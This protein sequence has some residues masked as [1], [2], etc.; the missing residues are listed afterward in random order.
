[1]KLIIS[2]L[3]LLLIPSNAW[4][5]V[6][7]DYPGIYIHQMGHIYFILSSAFILWTIVHN[8]LQN[9]KSWRYLFIGN[10]F[11][12]LW[13]LDAFI[14]HITEFWIEPS[15]I[16][17]SRDGWDYFKRVISLEGRE[18][19]YYFTKHDH[20]WLVPGMLFFYLGLK[21]HLKVENRASTTAAIL[22]LLPII[23]VDI[24][25]S[26][27]MIILSILSII[28]ALKLYKN[29]RENPL[30]NYMLWLS[31]S[32]VIFS[33]SRSLGHIINRTLVPTGYEHIWKIIEPYSG[34]LNTFTF[35]IV[36][37]VSL[38]FFRAY[39]SYLMMLADKTKIEVIN[40]DL[41][42]LNQELETMVA[43]R[44]M[45]LMAL[46][47]ADRVRNPASVIGWTC[48][49]I[50]DKEKVSERLGE[51]LREVINESDKLDT[52]VKD[53]ETLL[54]S[55]QSMFIYEDVNEIIKGIMPFVQKE[56]DV[57]GVTIVLNLTNYPLKINLQKNLL[58]AAIFHI[59]RNA[60]EATSKGGKVT[61]SSSTD[62]DNV[63]IT[64]SDTGHGIPAEYIDKIFETFF[65]TK[66]YRFGIG[67]PLA[68][69]IVSEHFGDIKVESEV[70]KGTTFKMIFP[71][72]WIGLNRDSAHLL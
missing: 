46:T 61:A 12:I 66:K 29:N 21:E 38:F 13:N 7:H 67:L 11:F 68:K 42:E 8:K 45:S 47:V 10:I 52:I 3:F 64:I 16:I 58:R 57:K 49:R 18:Y 32:F 51:T 43:E 30:W 41:A 55:R 17:G 69:Q 23:L 34:S 14:G 6:P 40:N 20:V 4:S 53:F 15:Q 27:I 65:S 33:L 62:N 60:I 39:Q 25:G 54:K 70:G 9:E 1:M 36:G 35:I 63:V 22:P 37:T 31:S 26:F 28:T 5:L 44:T 50:L 72:R 59:M 19:L 24:T 48:K 56:A 71:I 2:V